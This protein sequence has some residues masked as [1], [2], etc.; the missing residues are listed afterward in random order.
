MCVDC[1]AGVGGKPGAGRIPERCPEHRAAHKREEKHRQYLERQ[2]RRI[3]EGEPVQVGW[4]KICGEEIRRIG[5]CSVPSVCARCKVPRGKAQ[6]L[7]CGVPIIKTGKGRPPL[8]CPEHQA[9][10]R[11]K[12]ALGRAGRRKARQAKA[13][14]DDRQ[15]RQDDIPCE[16]C[17]A[18]M[19]APVRG[20]LR[21]RCEGC[22][23]PRKRVRRKTWCRKC[24]GEFTEGRSSR[25][26][27]TTCGERERRAGRKRAEERRKTARQLARSL[28]I[29]AKP[30][31]KA[32]EAAVPA[33]MGEAKVAAQARAGAPGAAGRSAADTETP[34]PKAERRA[35]PRQRSQTRRVEG[36]NAA[37][38]R[39]LAARRREEQAREA[40]VALR[41]KL[42]ERMEEKREREEE[43]YGLEA[44]QS[45]IARGDEEPE[46]LAA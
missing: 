41:R 24:G 43:W 25:K 11:A 26:Y 19:E 5:R 27:C 6:C 33:I 42:E 38:A 17:G 40:R 7:D 16:Q 4:C 2:E 22:R 15:S 9:V 23:P 21:K 12:R 44:R 18:A 30:R 1:G 31:R 13:R 29:P 20:P 37:E 3:A 39:V 8:R 34:R 46:P 35:E 32:V 45:G 36:G 28:G 10:Q 14:R